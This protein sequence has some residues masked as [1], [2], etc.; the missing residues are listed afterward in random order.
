MSRQRLRQILPELKRL[1]RLT[2][3]DRRNYLGTYDGPFVDCVC[4]CIKNLLNGRVP[5]KSK[6]LKTLRSYKRLLRKVALKT[7]QNERRWVLQTGGLCNWL[8]RGAAALWA[9]TLA[10]PLYDV[11]VVFLL[12]ISFNVLSRNY[13]VYRPM[14]CHSRLYSSLNNVFFT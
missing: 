11:Y 1:N 3:K 4:E 12:Q 5:L 6:Q 8:K 10:T 7:P 14:T 13:N 9:P 2:E